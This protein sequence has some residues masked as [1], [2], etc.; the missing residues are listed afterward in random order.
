[1]RIA[2]CLEALAGAVFLASALMKALDVTAFAVQISHYGIVRDPAIVRDIAYAT[3]ALETGL[4]VLLVTGVRLRGWTSGGALV[5]LAGFTVLIAY[6]WK[7]RNLEDCGC[8]GK[9][10]K[11]TPGV[12]IAKNIVLML[13]LFPVTALCVRGANGRKA[14][15]RISPR[16][17]LAAV[18]VSALA[19][20]MLA[21]YSAP[22]GTL[23][24]AGTVDPARPFA[25][26]EVPAEDGV[27]RL[28]QGEYLVAMLSATCE[29][30]QKAMEA[31]N[32]VALVPELPRPVGLVL[33]DEETL[34]QFE[35]TTQA[36]FPLM[37][38]EPLTFFQ[39]I[40]EAPPRLIHVR[41]GKQAAFWD[42]PIPDVTVLVEA[43]LVK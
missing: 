42:E 28:G 33:G 9:F 3:L 40:G 18:A 23:A 17:G 7:F 39:F 2:S 31:L 12:S 30:C 24:P 4:G 13:C 16:L 26:F 32:E 21:A 1:M 36:A 27:Y 25:Q 41:D 14:P 34:E 20:L 38:V 5:L 19:I 8:F 37:L 22:A 11:M 10:L 29:H 6:A 15:N 35:E 43:L